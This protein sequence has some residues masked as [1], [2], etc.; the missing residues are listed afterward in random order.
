M[1][2]VG[3]TGLTKICGALN[4]PPLVEDNHFSSLIFQILSALQQHQH[5]SMKR[6]VGE[7]CAT[8][9]LRK[10]TVLDDGSRKKRGFASLNRV[11]ALLSSCSIPRAQPSL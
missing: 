11:A 7:V 4:A 10:L 2:G 3:H 5:E 1:S 9:D 8:A 6:A